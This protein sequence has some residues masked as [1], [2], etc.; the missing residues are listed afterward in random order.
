MLDS[1]FQTEDVYLRELLQNALEATFQATRTGAEPSP[2]LI[3]TGVA[4]DGEPWIK[5]TDVGIGMTEKEPTSNLNRVFF[6]GWPKGKGETLG[7]GQFGFGFY[8]TFLVARE[9]RVISRSRFHPDKAHIWTMK[10]D[11]TTAVL[12]P[13]REDLPPLGTTVQ[14]FMPPHKAMSTD[15]ILDRLRSQYLYAP[16]PVFVDNIPLG[17]P[18]KEGWTRST[19]GKRI[20]LAEDLQERY[21]WYEP[22]LAVHPLPL[23]NGG[24][25]AIVPDDVIAPPFTIY[26]RG[27]KVTDTEI[28]NPP[29]NM[30]VCGILDMDSI[31]LKP[32]RESLRQDKDY[33]R[34]RQ[35]A[36][37]ASIAMFQDLR[38]RDAETMQRVF[39]THREYLI[40]SMLH[41]AHLRHAIGDSLPLPLYFKDR[42]T[43][44]QYLPL[45]EIRDRTTTAP[46]QW[47]NDRAADHLFADRARRLGGIPV[48]LDDQDTYRLLTMLSRDLRF[49]FQHVA[50]SYLEEMRDSTEQDPALSD[51]FEAVLDDDWHVLCVRD[52]DRRVPIKM[53]MPFASTG[54]ARDPHPML[55]EAM[56]AISEGRSEEFAAILSLLEEDDGPQVAVINIDNPLI[57]DLQRWARAPSVDRATLT[58]YA[59]IV[60]TL[61]KFM[62][63]SHL[64]ADEFADLNNEVLSLIHERI[65]EMAPQKPSTAE[66]DS[67]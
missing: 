24:V 10:R 51:L 65:L 46:I 30:I 14:V 53:I 42:K 21:A 13:I 52:V 4:S 39:Q 38:D 48:H 7:I 27:V 28:L 2:I 66:G 15:E 58:R 60:V 35:G 40:K 41:D 64:G 25:L 47:S 50:I 12:E 55:L 63:Q 45:R 29:L 9:V 26:R 19:S 18:R 16:Y 44:E 23:D 34:L 5:V 43:G 1:L 56:Q 54:M 6:S 22:P 31:S 17:I 32:D 67:K 49:S 61:A 3:T 37:Q 33:D 11:A 36:H 20:V 59:H 8:T 62:G 57:K